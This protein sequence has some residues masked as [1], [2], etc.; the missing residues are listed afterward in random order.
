MLSLRARRPV[1]PPGLLEFRHLIGNGHWSILPDSARPRDVQRLQDLAI[2][3]GF[4]ASQS[5]S[6][7]PGYADQA[8]W[9]KRHYCS[10]T[11][12]IVGWVAAWIK[13]GRDEG[14]SDWVLR[15]YTP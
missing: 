6:T 11:V 9:A 12:D 8:T 10:S 7:T 5:G 15:L 4:I 2:D 1:L 13:A 3:D 14:A